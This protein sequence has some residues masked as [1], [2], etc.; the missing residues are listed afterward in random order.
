MELVS[1]ALIFATKAHDNMRRKNSPIPYI[2][3]PLEAASIVAS[4]TADQE[5]IS[6]SLLHDVVEDAG[7]S[8][9]EVEKEFGPR[10]ARLVAAE[11]ENKREEID[12][13]LSWQIRK[14]EAIDAL[15]QS[16]DI[17]T[18]ILYLGDKLSNLRAI[19]IDKQKEGDKVWQKF[20]Q[21]D[22]EKHHWYY[23]TIAD[24]IVELKDTLAWQELDQLIRVVFNEEGE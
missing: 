7:I 5:I 21:K 19:Y 16:N 14:E 13:K 2:I 15:R 1:K 9:E 10:V 24:L 17:A 20:N 3:H 11:T 4:V 12:P 22:P 8:I 18:K 23:R 6:A